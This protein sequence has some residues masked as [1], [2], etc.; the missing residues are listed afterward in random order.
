MKSP[1]QVRDT[2]RIALNILKTIAHICEEQDL[3]YFLFYGSLIGGSQ[4]SRL[5][6]LGR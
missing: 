5:Y 4:A 3:R 6:S 1:L 2:Q